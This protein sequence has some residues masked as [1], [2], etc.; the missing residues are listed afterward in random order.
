M[1]F[2]FWVGDSIEFAEG[3]SK[4]DLADSFKFT[5]LGPSVDTGDKVVRWLIEWYLITN[6]I[7]NSVALATKPAPWI[8]AVTFVPNYTAEGDEIDSTTPIAGEAGDSIYTERSKWAPVRWTD[9]TLNSTQWWA[10]SPGV[11]DIRSSRLFRDKATDGIYFG[12]GSLFDDMVS[13]LDVTVSGWL[14]LKALVERP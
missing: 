5:N 11:A 4:D 3:T 13:A 6:L 1:A 10:G 12:V 14:R 9:G 8:A 7:E 2:T